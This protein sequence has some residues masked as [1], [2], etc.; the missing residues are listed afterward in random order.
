MLPLTAQAR[1]ARTS[2]LRTRLTSGALAIA[3]LLASTIIFTLMAN[4]ALE[5]DERMAG[6]VIERLPWAE[7]IARYD[8]PGA[9]FYLDPPYFGCEDDYGPGLF[10][11]DEFARMAE[12]LAGLKGRFI[13]SINDRPEIRALFGRF[14]VEPVGVSYGIAATGAIDARE[15]IIRG[16]RGEEV[17]G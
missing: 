9:L 13:L 8:S 3:L 7:F 11:R 10:G 16:C 1:I 14:E 5:R 2:R 17:D 4:Y 15:L 12:V 6:V